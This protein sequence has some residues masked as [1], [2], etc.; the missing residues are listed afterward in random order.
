VAP[1]QL[2]DL[3]FDPDETNNLASD[4]AVKAVLNDM[5]G[6]LE[7]WMRE[8]DDPLL[9]GPVPAPS[10]TQINDPDGLSPKDPRITVP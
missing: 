1:E 2:Y 7:K 3:V 4:L 6:R 9:K 8:T 10:G 5:R